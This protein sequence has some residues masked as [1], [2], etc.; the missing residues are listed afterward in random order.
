MS[1]I[2]N[3]R[4]YTKT[5]EWGLKEKES[6]VTVGISEHAQHRLGDIVFIELPNV[7][8]Q[9]SSGQDCAVV[10]SVKAAS[11]IY[12]PVSGEVIA[13][14][15]KLNDA[16]ETVNQSPYQ[17]GWLFQV[18]MSKPEEFD[19]LLEAQVYESQVAEEA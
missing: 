4:R 19:K 14:N 11:D 15:T 9:V 12:S 10:E 6:I 8:A 1:D 16:P 5:H 7:G 18:K 13:V 2:P 17:E 3:D